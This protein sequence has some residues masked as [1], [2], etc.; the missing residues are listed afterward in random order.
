MKPKPPPPQKKN[1]KQD[2][3]LNICAFAWFPVRK[4]LYSGLAVECSLEGTHHMRRKGASSPLLL[5][6]LRLFVDKDLR[7]QV[8]RCLVT[9][10]G[11]PACSPQPHLL[12]TCAGVIFNLDHPHA[13][14]GN[15][16]DPDPIAA[17]QCQDT[18]PKP[19]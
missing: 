8:E 4:C 1:K 16:F 5:A 13:C 6:V 11:L 19:P 7:G 18:Q 2:E 17:V 10:E 3:A 9:Q 14:L 12:L 15:L